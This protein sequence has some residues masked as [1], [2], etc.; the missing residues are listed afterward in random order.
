MKAPSPNWYFAEGCTGWGFET[1]LCFLNTQTSNANVSLEFTPAG[2]GG[3]PVKKIIVVP[4]GTRRT[5]KLNDVVPNQ[6]VAT[7]VNSDVPIVAERSMLWAVLGGRAGHATQGMTAPSKQVFM[8]EGCTAYG[9][10][11]W[12]LVQNPGTTAS[13]VSVYAMTAGG[14]QKIDQFSLAGGRRK[15]VRLNDYYQGN[16]SI[17]LDATAPVVCE[18]SMYWNNRG[19]GT[20]SIGY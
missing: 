9:F 8:S 17:H 3:A 12:L 11:T 7:K 20:S 18:R 6:D 15:S 16:L 10:D 19:G 4:A 14:E 13:D 2:S 5:L 1:Y